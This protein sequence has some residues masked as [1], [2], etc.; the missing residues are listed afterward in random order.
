DAMSL[1]G[2]ITVETANVELDMMDNAAASGP[3][4]MLAVS[5]NG[6]G[7]DEETKK[8]VFEPF[9]TTKEVGKGTGLGLSTVYGIVRQS[10][11]DISSHSETGKGASFEVFFP[12]NESGQAMQSSTA[13]SPTAQKASETIL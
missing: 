2:R 6:T 4:V 5:D 10:G 1:G 3:C 12:R 9:F 7:M 11:G 13:P 8:R